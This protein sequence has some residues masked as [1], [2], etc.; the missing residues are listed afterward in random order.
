MTPLDIVAAAILAILV[1][2]LVRDRRNLRDARAGRHILEAR[3]VELLEQENEA[4]R[5]ALGP[6]TDNVH[7]LRPADD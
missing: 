6:V 5:E 2:G 4:L 3:R 7:I 1:A